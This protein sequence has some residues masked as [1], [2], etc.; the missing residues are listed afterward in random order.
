MQRNM[1]VTAL[2]GLIKAGFQVDMT[3]RVTVC[4]RM[5]TLLRSQYGFGEVNFHTRKS[6]FQ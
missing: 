6:L 5:V 2:E 3:L 1:K 4:G